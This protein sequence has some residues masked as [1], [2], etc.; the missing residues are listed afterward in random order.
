MHSL[1]TVQ[2][3]LAAVLNS[4]RA[5]ETSVFL[6]RAFVHLRETINTNRK[7]ASK[8]VEL[9]RHLKGHDTVIGDIMV[10]SGS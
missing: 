1:N 10:Q 9:E 7:V 5:I 2:I 8:L 6:V 3:M 4:Q